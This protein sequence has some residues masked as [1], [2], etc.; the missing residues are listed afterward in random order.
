MSRSTRLH[1]GPGKVVTYA[2][3]HGK[4]TATGWAVDPDAPK[5]PVTVLAQL[6]NRWVPTTTRANRNLATL[7][8]TKTP[9]DFTV[10]IPAS[11]GRHVVCSFAVNIGAG[12][13]RGL[14]CTTL[15]VT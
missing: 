13:T 2:G 7:P 5:T 6:D 11:R 9:I 10:T 1:S 15:S 14:G 3:G 12:A 8:S 4:I